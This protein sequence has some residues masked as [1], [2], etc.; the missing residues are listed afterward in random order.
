MDFAFIR[1]KGREEK[2]SWV[3]ETQSLQGCGDEGA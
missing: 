2:R 3:Q 1:K